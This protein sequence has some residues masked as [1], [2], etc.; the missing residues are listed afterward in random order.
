MWL[1]GT[2]R[3]GRFLFRRIVAQSCS[4]SL[5]DG[6]F[7]ID[8]VVFGFQQGEKRLVFRT[9]RIQPVFQFV[10]SGF[11]TYLVIE[12]DFCISSVL[13]VDIFK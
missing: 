8:R 10:S 6:I 4:Q 9:S 12:T 2:T 1:S 13:A 3:S 5:V 7:V 11:V